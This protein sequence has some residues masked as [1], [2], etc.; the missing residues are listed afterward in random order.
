MAEQDGFDFEREPEAPELRARAGDPSTSHESMARMDLERMTSA[1]GLYVRLLKEHGPMAE[2]EV[3]PLF[4]EAYEFKSCDHLHQQARSS[5]RDQGLVRP[6]GEKRINPKTG[7][8]QEV[9]EAC[10]IPK[11]TLH[12]CPTCG[13]VTRAKQTEDVNGEAGA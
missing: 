2:F 13:H 4:Y 10:N 6:T 5:A 7:R 8:R 1:M 9:W 11:P 12:K 3:R